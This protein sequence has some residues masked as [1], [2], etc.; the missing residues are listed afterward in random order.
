MKIKQSHIASGVGD[1]RGRADLARRLCLQVDFSL[2]KRLLAYLVKDEPHASVSLCCHGFVLLILALGNS[3]GRIMSFSCGRDV[4]VLPGSLR[5]PC[6]FVASSPWRL[7]SYCIFPIFSISWYCVVIMTLLILLHCP[8][9]HSICH[10]NIVFNY[11]TSKSNK[12]RLLCDE[13]VI[14]KRAGSNPL[15]RMKAGKYHANELLLPDPKSFE[16]LS[17]A[18]KEC[19]KKIAAVIFYV[20]LQISGKNVI[21]F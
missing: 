4:Y 13:T 7:L 19:R 12:G 9:D 3:L 21:G 8:K 18:N 5:Q 20:K 11:Q 6:F 17:R 14:V 15:H 2:T 1:I 16:T 10:T